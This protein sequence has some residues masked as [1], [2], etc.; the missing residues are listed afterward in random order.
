MTRTL[1]I[2]LCAAFLAAA[3]LLCFV[4]SDELGLLWDTAFEHPYIALFLLCAALLGLKIVSFRLLEIWSNCAGSAYI[5]KEEQHLREQL[6]EEDPDLDE[7]PAEQ[8]DSEADLPV[9]GDENT[10]DE[11]GGK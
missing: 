1:F 5:S 4:F 3:A 6:F 9:L 11:P 10:A 7:D 2:V 8:K